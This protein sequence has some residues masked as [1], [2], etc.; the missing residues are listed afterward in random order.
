[1]HA[2]LPGANI[3]NGE[4]MLLK[5]R[6]ILLILSAIILACGFP[7]YCQLSKSDLTH[8]LFTDGY[9]LEDWFFAED[10]IGLLL[11]NHRTENVKGYHAYA[12]VDSRGELWI[13][14][15][16]R[17]PHLPRLLPLNLYCQSN[18]AANEGE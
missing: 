3:V 2:H 5:P 16:G 6:Y 7:A 17:C 13:F 4:V 12:L 11:F 10:N 14:V 1:M 8:D 9:Y 15:G 18:V